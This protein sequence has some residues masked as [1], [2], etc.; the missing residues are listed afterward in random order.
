[1]KKFKNK[2]I[3]LSFI[4]L[5]IIGLAFGLIFNFYITE[6]DKTI[7]KKELI[8]YFATIKTNY[9]YSKGLLN[10]IKTNFLYI[11]LIWVTGLVPFLFLINYFIIFYKGFL[12]GFTIA[13]II[14]IYRLKGLIISFVFLFPHEFINVLIFITLSV[15]SMKFSKKIYNKI[16]N[17]NMIDFKKDYKEYI[18]IYILLIILSFISSIFEIFFNSLLIRLVV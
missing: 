15:S 17:N 8:E 1:M 13:S 6:I 2:K 14:M 18:K 5:F 12:I 4:V 9:S 10:S 7:I 11:T 3:L 16:K